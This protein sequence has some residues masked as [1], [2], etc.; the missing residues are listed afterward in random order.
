MTLRFAKWLN[1]L[2]L[3]TLLSLS[4]GG[5]A[6]PPLP[7]ARAAPADDPTLVYLPLLMSNYPEATVFGMHVDN[8]VNQAGL[9]QAGG[10]WLRGVRLLWKDVEPNPGDR[11]WASVSGIDNLLVQAATQNLTPLLMVSHTPAWAQSLAGYECGPIAPEA[12]DEFGQ[13]MHDLV[14]RYSAPPYNV[15]YYEIWNEP[16]IDPLITSPIGWIGCW[17]DGNDDYYGG[18]N[19]AEMLK[20]IYPRMK[21]ANPQ[22]QILIG[23]L[24]SYCNPNVPGGCANAQPPS[25]KPY[26]FFEGILRHNG[27]NDGGQY[28]DGLDFTA[29]DYYSSQLGQYAAGTWGGAWNTTGPVLALKAQFFRNVMAQYNVANKMLIATE[30][31]VACPSA[32]CDAD[33]ELTKTYY[34]AQA[35]ATALKAGV[36]ASIWYSLEGWRQTGLIDSNNQPNQAYSAY[37]F[38]SQQLV[39][40]RFV[41][42][43][44]DYPGVR[45]Y[46]FSEP[47]SRLWMLW[48]LDGA[49][50]PITLPS[51]PPHLYSVTGAPLTATQSITVTLEPW[52]LEW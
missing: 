34:V 23:G 15:R 49:D 26:N 18:G 24:L 8:G 13:F 52:Y 25:D 38:A 50:H 47:G 7:A 36:T 30:V 42:E 21:E 45:A 46:E 9:A 20:A 44:T 5:P 4:V 37:Q 2:L 40:K 28:F 33:Y 1:S 35:Y 41:R 3:L 12:L 32:S 48:S 29:Y 11:N 39:G 51:V 27:M 19:F 16:D 14:A 43:V 6:T 31:A 17:G 10:T 22:A